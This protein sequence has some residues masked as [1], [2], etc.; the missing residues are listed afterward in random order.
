MHAKSSTESILVS[1]S[2][3][4]EIN[5]ILENR[6]GRLLTLPTTAMTIKCY[7][8]HSENRWQAGVQKNVCIKLTL[9]LCCF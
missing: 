8:T 1:K 5:L 9:N 3:Y 7:V 4:L 6:E 2:H